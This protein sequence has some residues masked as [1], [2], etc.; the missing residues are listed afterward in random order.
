MI[1]TLDNFKIVTKDG[2]I[3]DMANDF[4]VLVKKLTIFSPKPQIYTET[5]DNI[6]GSIRL[7]KTWGERKIIAECS[8]F[9]V[10]SYDYALLR[11]KLFQIFMILDEFYLIVDSEPGKRWLVEVS[12][13]WDPSKIGTYSDF[14]LNFISH[15]SFSESIGT[16]LDPLTF[17][18]ELWQIGQGLLADDLIYKLNTNTFK[19]YNA[20]DETIDPEKFPL[21]IKYQGESNNLQIK[22]LTTL[23]TWTYN[24]STAAGESIEINRTRSLKNGIVP[25]FGDTNRKLIKLAPGWNDFELVGA[26]GSFEIS[27]DFRFYYF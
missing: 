26:V 11:N 23:N 14:M 16:T 3:F 9:A 27:F 8:S 2:K 13:E 25:V 12:D 7:G 18:A 19:I 24:G 17:D 5:S 15:S 4:G 21:I 20:G 10:D 1:K 6:N 22:N